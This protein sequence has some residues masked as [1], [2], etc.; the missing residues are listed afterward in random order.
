MA[1]VEKSLYR[2][3]GSCSNLANDLGEF[4]AKS[5]QFSGPPSENE[6]LEP[7]LSWIHWIIHLFN[8]Y[9]LNFLLC[10]SY[11]NLGYSR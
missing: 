3:L 5:L 11:A 4:G 6:E 9:L 8:K 7:E 10:F 1:H 2:R